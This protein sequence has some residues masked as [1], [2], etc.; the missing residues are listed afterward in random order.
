MKAIVRKLWEE[1]AAFLGALAAIVGLVAA[2]VPMPEWLRAVLA[3]G[4][5]LLA[6][7]GTR[8]V[9]KPIKRKGGAR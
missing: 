3:T 7:A 8:Q 2:T 1:P 5:P 6:A 4:A 9:V